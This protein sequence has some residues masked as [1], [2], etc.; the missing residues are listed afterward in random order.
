[1]T[2]LKPCPFCGDLKAEIEERIITEYNIKSYQV[3]CFSCAGSSGLHISQEKA[4]EAW[5]RRT[6][7]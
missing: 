5:N 1:M 4:I 3:V 7:E 2:E 6:T